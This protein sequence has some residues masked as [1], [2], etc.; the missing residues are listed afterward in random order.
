MSWFTFGFE[1]KPPRAVNP[2]SVY[3]V[4]RELVGLMSGT[5][6]EVRLLRSENENLKRKLGDMEMG[7]EV[8]QGHVLQLIDLA[9]KAHAAGAA[10]VASPSSTGV[11][12]A[13]IDALDKSVVDALNVLT[14][15][16]AATAAAA[17]TAPPQPA[18]A[19]TDT[20]SDPNAP[21]NPVI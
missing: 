12:Q 14:P 21:A 15:Q 6:A 9:E 7:I 16:V 19:A 11:D 2:F 4:L 17:N 20:L 10:A 8:L 3:K 13:A 5:R 1:Q 18:P